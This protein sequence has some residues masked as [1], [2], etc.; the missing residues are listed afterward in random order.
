MGIELH[1]RGASGSAAWP[2]DTVLLRFGESQ[3][4]DVYLTKEGK[5]VY[6]SGP[7]RPGDIDSLQGSDGALEVLLEDSRGTRQ[8]PYSAREVKLRY[9]LGYEV[10]FGSPRQPNSV[11]SGKM[12]AVKVSDGVLSLAELSF[13]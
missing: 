6:P 3:L 1:L 2:G 4:R 8:G 12:W 9:P 10:A 13:E 7:L 5:S 11:A